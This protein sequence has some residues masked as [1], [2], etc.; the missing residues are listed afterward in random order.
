M[1]LTGDRS[2]AFKGF[3]TFWTDL[4][5]KAK[6]VSYLVILFGVTQIVLN[7]VH[8]FRIDDAFLGEK[9]VYLKCVFALFLEGTP[10]EEGI[11]FKQRGVELNSLQL[12]A[13]NKATVLKFNSLILS[14]LKKSFLVWGLIPLAYIGFWL[15][16]K[17]EVAKEHIR[18][19][20]LIDENEY[21]KL[22]K[23]Y[24]KRIFI[25]E[26][27]SVPIESECR[28]FFLVGKS[29][30]GKTQFFNRSIRDLTSSLDGEGNIGGGKMIIYDRKGSF[31]S[32]FYNPETDIIFN[33]LDQ[34]SV[35]WS[36]F[37]EIEGPEHLESISKSLF[38]DP[39][40]FKENPFF[41]IASRS[42]FHSLVTSCI[43]HNDRN[44]NALYHK[45]I[46]PIEDMVE[47]FSQDPRMI[48][49]LRAIKEA[50]SVGDVISTFSQKVIFL[51][52]I[53]NQ[54]GDFSIRD[55]VSDP[56]QNGKI[57]IVGIKELQEV[58]RPLYSLFIDTLIGRILSLPDDD[59][60][61]ISLFLDEFG[62]LQAL[63]NIKE[64]LTEARS[65]GGAAY[66]G[67]QDYGQMVDLYGQNITE[68]IVNSCSNT[69]IF[70]SE[71]SST[72][73]QS[74]EKIGTAEIKKIDENLSYGPSDLKDGHSISKREK[75]EH[76]VL[77]SEIMTL[78]DLQFY[79]KL[80]V[81]PHF[82]L[83]SM[84]YIDFEDSHSPYIPINNDFLRIVEKENEEV[85]TLAEDEIVTTEEIM[86]DL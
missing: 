12:L 57:F 14:G 67:V 43:L 25:N 37:N 54:K 17:R 77:P 9:Y 11:F 21:K 36:I 62:S 58:L 1:A 80:S 49:G 53:R 82:T 31:I 20:K 83:T 10:M 2:Q 23:K 59:K 79:L 78:K 71:D 46:A 85:F 35:Q 48:R 86:E 39:T 45:S 7:V 4:R 84:K 28:H 30:S 34:R 41:P 81:N 8:F 19:R 42:I 52:Y 32:K 3:E 66:I 5:M 15:R 50:K 65:K 44:N 47:M 72:A 75:I 40:G 56:K 33:P 64:F 55:W 73:R 29:G 27:I 68:S 69:F 74:S 6:M 24:L 18:G 51:E 13:V 76:I 26:K 60:R 61:R 63:P 38:P 16:S 22:L 70:A